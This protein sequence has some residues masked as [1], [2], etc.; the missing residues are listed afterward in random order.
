MTLSLSRRAA[1]EYSLGQFRPQVSSEK[2]KQKAP[3]GRPRLDD[4]RRARVAYLFAF[5]REYHRRDAHRQH[6][7]GLISFS[8]TFVLFVSF[9]VFLCQSPRRR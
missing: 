4:R 9:V 6:F 2:N 1:T 8:S 3:S 7:L 5:Q